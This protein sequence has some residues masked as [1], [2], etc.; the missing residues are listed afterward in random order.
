MI[1]LPVGR[2]LASQLRLQEG[3]DQRRDS[4]A[5]TARYERRDDRADIEARGRCRAADP[6]EGIYHLTEDPTAQCASD[7]IA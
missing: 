5:D 2:V 7:G 1:T 4:A 6:Q 3:D